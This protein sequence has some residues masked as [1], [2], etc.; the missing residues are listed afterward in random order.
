MQMIAHQPIIL[1]PKI[2]NANKKPFILLPGLLT[3]HRFL[4]S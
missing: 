2:R 4:V 1:E 3:C